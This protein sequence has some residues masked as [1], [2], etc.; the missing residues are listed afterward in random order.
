MEAACFGQPSGGVLGEGH[1]VQEGEVGGWSGQ[2][3][4]EALETSRRATGRSVDGGRAG[5]C[6]RA[7]AGEQSGKGRAHWLGAD[8]RCSEAW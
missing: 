8:G 1:A 5:A 6:E 3:E 4:G 7:T 2:R